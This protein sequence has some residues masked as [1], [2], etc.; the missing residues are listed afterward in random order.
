MTFA[1]V[2]VCLH[3]DVR[4]GCRQRRHDRR[5]PFDCSCARR[6]GLGAFLIVALLERQEVFVDGQRNGCAKE[7]ELDLTDGRIAIVSTVR[8][9]L[10]RSART[11]A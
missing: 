10:R 1:C 5:G 8:T 4:N 2:L 9:R 3:E 11:V 7:P 6:R